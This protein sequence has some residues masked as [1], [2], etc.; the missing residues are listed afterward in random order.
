MSKYQC[1]NFLHLV[2]LGSVAGGADW[3]LIPEIK[4]QAFAHFREKCLAN[5]MEQASPSVSNPVGSSVSLEVSGTQFLG[6][7]PECLCMGQ[8]RDATLLVLERWKASN[9]PCS[10]TSGIRRLIET[11]ISV[12]QMPPADLPKAW[13]CFSPQQLVC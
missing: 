1:V 4:A 6:L 5:A 13:I 8:P 10:N 3:S 9:T 12:I 11:S 2:V 7:S